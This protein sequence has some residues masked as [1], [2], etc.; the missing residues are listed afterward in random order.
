[1]PDPAETQIPARMEREISA[2]RDES[3][4]RTLQNPSGVNLCSND[5]LGLAS[6]PRLKAATIAAV[7]RA[8]TMGSTGSRLM[9]GNSPEWEALEAE[10]AEFDQRIKSLLKT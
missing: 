4:F 10:F 7:E 9:S 8:S 2:L 3:Q 5:Y 1:M 6:E